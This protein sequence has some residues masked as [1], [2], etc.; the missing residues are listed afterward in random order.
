M[1]VASLALMVLAQEG[2]VRGTVLDATL[3]A[4]VAAALVTTRA[5]SAR[6][7]AA[8]RFAIAAHRGDT[9][10][11]Q[12]IGY[13]ETRV[14]VG[15]GELAIRMIPVAALLRSMR[16]ADSTTAARMISTR[17][18]AELREQ[19]STGLGAAIAAMPFVSA[20]GARGENTISLRGA[21]PEQV[22]VVVDGMPLN[23]PS[24][25]RADVSDIPLSA[26]GAIAVAGGSDATAY[27]SGASGGVVA[28]ST[29][30][31]STASLFGSSLGG[32][33]AEGAYA[34]APGTSRIRVG[35]SVSSAQNRYRFLNDAGARDTME[36]RD[37]AD[38]R[39][40]ALFTSAVAGRAQITALVA[41]RERGLAGPKN[42]REYDSAR[43]TSDR[44]FA[45][46]RFGSDRMITSVGVRRLAVRYRDDRDTGLAS[47]AFGSTIDADIQ[48][49]LGS[50]TLRA[51]GAREHV[52]GTGLPEADR[53][54][55]FAGGAGR[56]RFGRTIADASARV[57]GAGGT[58]M[59]FSPTIA[60][61]REGVLRPFV[62][63]AQGFRLPAFYDLYIP[64]PLGFVA[65]RVAP[66]R[67]VLDGEAGVR[68]AHRGAAIVASVFERRTDDAI[69]WFPGNFSW[70]PKNVPRE[71]VRGA[72]ARV[73]V[74]RA[75]AAAELWGAHYTTRLFVDGITIPTPYVPRL[76]GGA[77]GRVTAG[78][79][80]LTASLSARGRRA[81]AI[82]APSRRLEL[83]GVLLADVHASYRLRAQRGDLLLSAGV[84][85]VGNT[86]SESVR[87]FPVPG[88]SWQAGVTVHP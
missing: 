36:R 83:P 77:T 17:T 7:D 2:P 60:V 71:R 72:E 37:N 30:D 84:L 19:G 78:R 20:R 3:G 69:I 43:E 66:E 29:G 16:V 18:V 28:L 34:F 15:E 1:I 35:A 6:T 54:S 24:T 21:R 47:D 41:V 12:R 13:R 50:V 33:A 38:E 49:T 75:R 46:I 27:G 81:Y 79:A 42:V 4:P 68:A 26:L 65:T 51:G 63:I 64:S 55:L 32:V 48:L 67:V 52:W 8:G 40:G 5:A 9:L 45:R 23:D 59:R 14:V 73:T 53:H 22:L 74:A 10:R 80:T 39:R 85:N 62:R 88:R 44:R 56:L 70:S 31:G 61:E 11:V 76:S 58:T 57:D 86:P 82:A 25:G 87:R